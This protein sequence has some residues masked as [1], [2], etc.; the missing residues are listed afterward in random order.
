[1]LLCGDVNAIDCDG[2]MESEREVDCE[3]NCVE[4]GKGKRK[5]LMRLQWWV[6][7]WIKAASYPGRQCT[8]H[9]PLPGPSRPTFQ[10]HNHKHLKEGGKQ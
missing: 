6:D 8:S 2:E 4:I 3:Q 9:A 10:P 1:M 7:L 5:N